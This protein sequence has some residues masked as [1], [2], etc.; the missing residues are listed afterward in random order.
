MRIFHEATTKGGPWSGI[1]DWADPSKPICAMT[2]VTC[3]AQGHVIGISLKNRHLQGHIPDSIGLL[4]FLETLDVSDNSLM[5]YVPSDLQWTSIQQLDVSGNKIR[6]LIPPLLC[7]MEALN[8]NGQGSVFHCD[9]IACPAGTYNSFGYQ[10]GVNGE[11]CMPCFDGSPYVGQTYCSRPSEP[12]S[13]KETGE[14]MSTKVASGIQMAKQATKQMDGSTKVGI[15]VSIGTLLIATLVCWLVKRVRSHTQQKEE[16]TKEERVV[17]RRSSIDEDEDESLYSDETPRG[18]C[19]RGQR[20]TGHEEER[21]NSLGSIENEESIGDNSF[22]GD[23]EKQDPTRYRASVYRDF[24]DQGDDVYEDDDGDGNF[25]PWT[26]R[27]ATDFV[28]AHQGI[29][30]TKT[31][32][33][34]QAGSERVPQRA[35]EAVSRIHVS[36]RQADLNNKRRL[37]DAKMKRNTFS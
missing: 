16:N 30:M 37:L 26:H 32:K 8:G 12:G 21:K 34:K 15:V 3:D 5:G 19:R 17:L 36:S 18:P 10:H 22:S 23:H 27:K 35:R 29:A 7:K 31:D 14:Q 2:G 25:V 24:D 1:S 4:T 33:L 13:W 6:G 20:Q 11:E 9:R 28:Q